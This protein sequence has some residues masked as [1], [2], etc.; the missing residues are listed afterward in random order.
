MK[1]MASKW[2]GGMALAALLI[3][4]SPVAHSGPVLEETSPTHTVFT[5]LTDYL[6]M[7]GTGFG[8][9]TAQLFAVDLVLPPG[10]VPSSDTS[11]CEAADFAGFPAGSI[12]LM[13]RGTCTFAQKVLNAEA[14]GAAGV[15]IFNEGQPGRT[16]VL[17]GT[18]APFTANVVVFG[19]SFAVGNELSNGVLNGP[20]GLTVHTLFVPEPAALALVGIGLAGLGFSRRKQ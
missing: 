7:T 20:T 9:V 17:A 3:G 13:Q 14:A 8:D 19:T 18:L 11:G 6:E 12:A 16:D 4:A 1:R 15:L 2:L 10:P 5:Y